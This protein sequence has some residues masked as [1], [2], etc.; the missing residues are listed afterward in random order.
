MCSYR[1]I[2]I[3]AILHWLCLC[4]LLWGGGLGAVLAQDRILERAYWT[5]T[6]G[7]A[8]FAQARL[9]AYTPYSGVLSKG[10]GKQAQW[11]RLQIDAVDSDDTD[12][13]VLRIRPVFLDSITLYDAADLAKGREARSTGDSIP[14]LSTEFESLHHTFVIPAQTSPRTVWVRL[15]TTS[16]HLMHIE[17]LSPREMLRQEHNLWLAC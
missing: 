11:V 15:A 4:A 17:A 6:T 10:F 14:F 2:S 3:S 12:T 7:Q 1:P 9:A 8:S 16:T 13:L 5:D